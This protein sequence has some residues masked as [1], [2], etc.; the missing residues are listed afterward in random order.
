MLVYSI[1]KCITP[2]EPH[3][4]KLIGILTTSAAGAGPPQRGKG[5]KGGAEALTGV[6]SKAEREP[7]AR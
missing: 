5:T 7:P 1:V 6:R 3:Q 4:G 2:A